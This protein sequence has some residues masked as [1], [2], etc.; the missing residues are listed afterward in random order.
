M[1]KDERTG[2][3]GGSMGEGATVS[4]RASWDEYF[5]GIAAQVATRATWDR[6]LVGAVIVRDRS[7]LAS[8]YNGTIIG[9]PNCDEVGHLM[10]DGHCVR[11]IHAEANALMQA[12]R[13]GV[14]I[15]GGAIYVTASPCF[16]CFKL[17]ANAG[18]TRVVYGE[19]YRDQRIFDFA[20]Q[21]GITLTLLEPGGGTEQESKS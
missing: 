13:N 21:A 9:L 19:F 18:I 2:S 5:M 8:G 20:A 16:N 7:I 14:R 1:A 11:T 12:A 10:E 6:K 4:R 3:P 17:L 15:D